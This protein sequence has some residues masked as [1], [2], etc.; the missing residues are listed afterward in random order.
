MARDKNQ[1]LIITIKDR[2]RMCYTCVR[3]CPAKAI[4]IADG[5]AEVM[6]K[7][8][9]GCGNCVRVCSQKAKK[10][11]SSTFEVREFLKSDSQ[12]AAIV[13]PSFP[14]EF[15]ELEYQTFVSMIR[16]LGFAFVNEVSFGADLYA[17]EMINH[18]AKN[19]E[20]RYIS[21][22]CPAVFAYI[23]RYHEEL[24]DQLCPIVSPMVATGRMLREMHGKNLK[25]IFIGPCIAKMAEAYSDEMSGEIDE[26]LTFAEIRQMWEEDNIQSEK[27]EPTDFDPPYGMKGAIFPIHR[28]LLE[29]SGINE[30]LLEGDIISANGRA[31]FIDAVMQFGSGEI[32]ARLLDVLC[33]DGCIMGAGMTSTE[34]LLK[35]RFQVSAY[36]RKSQ[37]DRN[38]DEW[39]KWMKRFENLDLSRVFIPFN[40]RIPDPDKE[41]IRKILAGMGKFKPEDELNCGACGYETCREHSIAIYKGLAESEMCLPYTIERLHKVIKE[42]NISHEQLD[43]TRQALIQSEKMASMGQLAAGIAHE[44]NNP[45]GVVLMYAHLLA[46]DCDKNSEIYG[47]LQMIVDQADRC[48]KIVAGLL[49]FARQTKVQHKATNISEMIENYIKTVQIP[50]NI[51]IQI[52]H[53]ISDPMAEIDYDQ[54]IQVLTNLVNNSLTAMPNGGSLMLKT[55]GDADSIKISIGDTGIGIPKEHMSKIFE[56]FFT[57]KKVGQGT[58]L[59]LSIIYGIIKMHN[60]DISVESNNDPATGPTGTT[61]TITLPRKRKA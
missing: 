13:A 37:Q 33:C 61:F 4:R 22:A 8:C 48:K 42:L 36:A 10:V 31:N 44:V 17:R 24:I 14:A 56:P 20:K 28:G 2:C 54:I 23:K 6:P 40:Q 19:P 3:E 45:L 51:H 1:P 50:A 16:K 52:L 57:T 15:P 27:V 41:T 53:G 47:D 46:E 43:N 38:P 32:N 58:G 25:V 21:T 12:V 11:L 18:L 29:A 60:G 7:R 49:N 30:D 34:P 39:E 35:R 26:V 55:A 59:G 5:Q 9:I